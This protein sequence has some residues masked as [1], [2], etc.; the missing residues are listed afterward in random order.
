MSK[1]YIRDSEEFKGITTIFLSNSHEI[2]F[3]TSKLEAFV[4]ANEMN[5]KLSNC[6]VGLTCDPN[7]REW[8]E[9]EIIPVDKYLDDNWNEVVEKYY[10]QVICK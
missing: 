2:K 9:N 8:V 7:C 6:G 1:I 10:N 4:I 3:E 5:V